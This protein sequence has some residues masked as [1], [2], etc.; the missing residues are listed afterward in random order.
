M[1]A[2]ARRRP[3][4]PEPRSASREHRRRD[5]IMPGDLGNRPNGSRPH[6]SITF[7][8]QVRAPSEQRRPHLRIEASHSGT[9]RIYLYRPHRPSRSRLSTGIEAPRGRSPRCSLAWLRRCEQGRRSA[10]RIYSAACVGCRNP[11]C[12]VPV[13]VRFRNSAAQEVGP[14]LPGR[15]SRDHSGWRHAEFRVRILAAGAHVGMA[16]V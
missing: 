14:L 3:A 15:S 13:S 1:Q 6:P 16:C 9:R 2:R 5:A 4:L 11:R 8:D 7:R 12:P 10:L